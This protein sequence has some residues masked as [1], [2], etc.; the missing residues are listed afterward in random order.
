VEANGTRTEP[1]GRERTVQL[2]L[3]SDDGET[4]VIRQFMGANAF[5]E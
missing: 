4:F 5:M 3:F 2:M 1:Y